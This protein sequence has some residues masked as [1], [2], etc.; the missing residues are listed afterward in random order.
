MDIRPDGT[1]DYPDWVLRELDLVLVSIHS[2]FKLP[3]ADQTKRLLKALE[4]PFVHVLAHPTARLLGRRAPIEADWEAVFK[5]ALERRV[6][7]EIDGYYDRM[8]LPDDQARMA[9]GMGLW[10]SLSTDATRRTTSASW[11]SPWARPK[12]P[13]SAP[14][15][16]STPWTTRTSSPGS[17]PG[18]A[19]SSFRTSRNISRVSLPV[20]V[21]CRETW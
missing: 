10:I 14:S 13:G 11:S 17:K 7:V 2:Q 5:K 6:A 8:D 9:Y 3:K 21:F 1:L 15:G 16:C 12:G 20:W 18:E 19:L 4:N